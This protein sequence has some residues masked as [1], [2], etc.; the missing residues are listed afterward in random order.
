MRLRLVRS[1]YERSIVRVRVDDLYERL[2]E[3]QEAPSA[4]RGYHLTGPRITR[5]EVESNATY[6]CM[7]CEAVYECDMVISDGFRV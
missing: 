5:P 3:R 1:P 2:Y 4:E 6:S 7:L